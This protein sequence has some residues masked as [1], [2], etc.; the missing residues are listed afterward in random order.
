MF[1]LFR[2]NPI[3]RFRTYKMSINEYYDTLNEIQLCEANQDALRKILVDVHD[4]LVQVNE[5]KKVRHDD[6]YDKLSTQ[7]K[8]NIGAILDIQ[9][10]SMREMENITNNIT[11]LHSKL[12]TLERKTNELEKDLSIKELAELLES[13]EDELQK[14]EDNYEN[15]FLHLGSY[16]ASKEYVEFM[17]QFP[18][19]LFNAKKAGKASN[20][21]FWRTLKK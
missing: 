1:N 14:L 11:S 12:V 8:R 4:C 7:T 5:M 10:N 16:K 21:S 19:A 17:M 3:D 15:G 2:K 20:G 9:N 13:Y 18:K 6:F